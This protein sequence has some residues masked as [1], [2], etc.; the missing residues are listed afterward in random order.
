MV[1]TATGPL[2]K[3]LAEPAALSDPSALNFAYLKQGILG[4]D[5]VGLFPPGMAPEG[6]CSRSHAGSSL[7]TGAEKGGKNIFAKTHLGL[8]LLSKSE[9]T[10]A[11][12]FMA[13]RKTY[14]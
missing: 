7:H 3:P 9:F 11:W 1:T 2:S 5:Q 12:I 6:L 10:E 8:E 14:E 4:H 13:K